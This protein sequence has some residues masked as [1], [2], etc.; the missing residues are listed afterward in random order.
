M[1]RDVGGLA[2]EEGR[3]GGEGDEEAM[4]V[5]LSYEEVRFFGCTD[6]F[7]LVS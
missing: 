7:A 3:G 4:T 5:T 2:A 1:G 6:C